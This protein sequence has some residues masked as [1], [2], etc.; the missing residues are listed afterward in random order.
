MEASTLLK[1]QAG[2]CCGD[3]TDRNHNHHPTHHPMTREQGGWETGE[4]LWVAQ[5]SED[6]GE[7]S[8]G[9][10]ESGDDGKARHLIQ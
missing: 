7:R 4:G 6:R 10:G 2:T 5:E 1:Q 9:C 3:I 8:D